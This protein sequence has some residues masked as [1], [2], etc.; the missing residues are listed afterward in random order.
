MTDPTPTLCPACKRIAPYGTLFLRG[1]CGCGLPLVRIGR[2]R[3]GASDLEVALSNSSAQVEDLAKRLAIVTADYDRAVV[4]MLEARGALT[5]ECKKVDLLREMLMMYHDAD[6]CDG[7]C[8][9]AHILAKTAPEEDD[10][11]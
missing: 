7:G 8:I 2:L 11:L 4:E 10:D 6:D 9:V 5:A 1:H 3:N